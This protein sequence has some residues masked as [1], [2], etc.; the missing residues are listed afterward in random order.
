MVLHDQD[1]VLKELHGFATATSFESGDWGITTVEAIARADGEEKWIRYAGHGTFDF[2]HAPS[3]RDSRQ[4]RIP[5]VRV[6]PI[7]DYCEVDYLLP[8][9]QRPWTYARAF[10]QSPADLVEVILDAFSR[11]ENRDEFLIETAKD[12]D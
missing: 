4:R 11:C 2:Y 10:P 1:Q 6:R 5:Q 8:H 3:T 12:L 9:E 7:I